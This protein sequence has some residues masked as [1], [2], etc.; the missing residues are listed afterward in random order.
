MPWSASGLRHAPSPGP[1]GRGGGALHP[2]PGHSALE[3]GRV[4]IFA[5]GI[6]NPYFT[7]DTRP[8]CG[9]P[10]I[11]AVMLLKGEKSGVD[12]VYDADP[13]VDPTAVRNTSGSSSWSCQP[14]FGVMDQT[15]I[16]LCGDHH[17]P[18][19]VFALPGD[20]NLRRIVL[21]EQGVGTLVTEEG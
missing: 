18:V 12:G 4:V 5:A 10:E 1:Y 21:G 8:L 2:A 17:L 9:R 7:T 11:E 20:D 15:A 3:K 16:T 13:Q 6:G 14:G 19:M